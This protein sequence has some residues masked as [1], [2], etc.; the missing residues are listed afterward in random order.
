MPTHHCGT[1]IALINGNTYSQALNARDIEHQ[2][3][4]VKEWVQV[5]PRCDRDR[6]HSQAGT[7][8]PFLASDSV[9]RTVT[10]YEEDTAV[11]SEPMRFAR[12]AMSPDALRSA[13]ALYNEY[14][15]IRPI[16]ARTEYAEAAG[17]AFAKRPTPDAAFQFS[18]AVCKW[19][20]GERV[21][22]KLLVRDN[23]QQLAMRLNSCLAKV[24]TCND[25]KLAIQH[26]HSINGFGISFASKHLRMLV[27]DSF[28]VLDD[29][30]SVG[31]GFA[32]NPNGY[33]L[34]RSMLQSFQED[35][36]IPGSLAQLEGALFLLVRQHVRSTKS[37]RIL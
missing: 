17:R 2:P 36:A 20:G 21:W 18:K 26:V 27:P 37:P 9:M 35:N 11:L 31:L 1:S 12:F 32:L 29:V 22:G 6:L 19:G 3:I 7:S 28:P 24:L 14:D 16:T 23:R 4:S 5:C 15:A 25:A 30:L 34:F 13:Y 33:V 8:L 10:E